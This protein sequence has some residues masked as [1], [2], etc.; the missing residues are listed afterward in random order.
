VANADPAPV[1][2]LALG[3]AR[4]M[5]SEQYRVGLRAGLRLAADFCRARAKAFKAQAEDDE[6]R[7]GSILTLAQMQVRGEL[8]KIAAA[9]K[10]LEKK[11]G[12]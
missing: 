4:Q 7:E 11:A 6:I 10:E 1:P 8:N 5:A 12:R 9:I 2:D 3:E